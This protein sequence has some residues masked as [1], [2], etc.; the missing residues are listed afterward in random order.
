ML[1]SDHERCIYPRTPLHEV[2]CQLRFPTILTIGTREPADFQEAI[3]GDFPRFAVRQDVPAPKLNGVGTAHPTVENQPPVTNYHFVSTDGAWKL[4]L[5]QDFIALSTLHYTS[6]E[7]FAHMLDQPL[8]HFIRIYQPAF[9]ERIGLRYLNILSR[10][11]LGLEGHDWSELIESPY[12]GPLSQSDV[13]EDGV[14]KCALDVEMRLDSSC[15]VRLHAG[16]GRVQNGAPGAPQDQE[17]KFILD[18]DLFMSGSSIADALVPG[19]LET[20][21]GHSTR[22]FQ[23][24]VTDTLREAMEG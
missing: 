6:W 7:A 11:Q 15:Q 10:R 17:V 4:N 18:L 9:F 2:I 20:L 19:A 1:F 13:R 16:P 12:L 8:G 5:T 22:L 14:G 24:A 23:G 21:H 3:R